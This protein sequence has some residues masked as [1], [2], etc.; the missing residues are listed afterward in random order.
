[1]Y[2]CPHNG[3]NDEGRKAAGHSDFFQNR[4]THYH[5]N[6]SD[7]RSLRTLTCE[8]LLSYSLQRRVISTIHA[9]YLAHAT[10]ERIMSG[11]KALALAIAA[12]I[13]T[14]GAAFAQ[15]SV[16]STFGGP[17][18]QHVLLISIDGMHQLDLA[19]W[20]AHNPD[21]SLAR[22]SG[23]AV[24][25]TAARAT[26][27]SDS[28]P[29][30]LA[31][32][33]GGTPKSTG[34]Y[35]DDSYDRTLYAPGSNCTGNS[36]IE[37]VYDESLD[38]DTTQLFSGGINP[39]YLPM[40]KGPSGQCTPVYPHS[41]LKTNTVFEVVKQAGGR[42]AWADKHP[43]YDL[44]NGPSGTGVDDLYVPEVNSLIANGGTVNGVNLGATLSR[45]DGTNSLPIKKV[46]DYTNCI[47][48]IEAYDDVKVQAIINEIDGLKSDGSSVVGVPTLFGLNF[49]GVSVGQKLPVGGYIDGSGTPSANLREALTHT[50]HAIGRMVAELDQRNLLQSTLIV[51]S[52]K[53]GQSPINPHA[54]AMEEGGRG[55]TTVQDPAGFIAAADPTVDSPSSF[56]NPN[57]GTTLS[58]SGH[59]QT[60][61]VGLLWLQNQSTANL[62]NVEVQLQTNAA[63]IHADKMPAGTI[64]P[65]NLNSGS[66]LAK[67]FGSP[68]SA[69]T[70][71]YARA[72]NVLIQPNAGVIYSGSSKKIAE[73]GGG[74]P[75]DTSVPLLI[76][77]P[78][79]H[80][81]AVSRP[82]LTTQI[83]P[84]ILQALN[85]SPMSLRA[86]RLER[87][88]SLQYLFT[89]QR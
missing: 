42:T 89:P 77:L 3:G 39:S 72:P 14:T 54:L 34:V 73:H 80:G 40:Q 8:I 86:A 38:H 18:V 22:L 33:T 60:D 32:V 6:C 58:T 55:D 46:K 35:Y 61:D 36:G 44:V 52:A 48:A 69:D 4:S 15:Q 20:I 78:S 74:T 67:L 65:S 68:T 47:P 59:F 71:A 29:G 23:K 1:M 53:H 64:L 11:L 10:T 25:F 37:V 51:I 26:T 16:P 70:V 43:A 13:A 27:P 62:A 49:Q 41:F 76:S 88:S 9:P 30:L 82:V 19:N 57:S 17:R 84:T 66:D 85:L 79:I 21:S 63:S 75:D 24:M 5:R 31:M 87:T 2:E 50:D 81:H 56:T 45:C 28:F 12:C 7:R 83:A